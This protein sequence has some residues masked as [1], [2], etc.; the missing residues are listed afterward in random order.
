MV[1]YEL[2]IMY[3]LFSHEISIDTWNIP[4]FLEYQPLPGEEVDR[5]FGRLA[6]GDLGR[7]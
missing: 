7:H 4:S 5:P 3:R 6:H 1:K 2:C